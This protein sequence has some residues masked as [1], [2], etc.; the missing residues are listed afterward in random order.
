MINDIRNYFKT[1]I[2]EVDSDLEEHQEYFVNN[3]IDDNNKEETYFITMGPM[4]I[5]RVDSNMTGTM[6]VSIEIWKNG[7]N[8]IIENLDEAYC[9]SIDIQA[10]AMDQS[11]IDQTSYIKSVVG[12]SITPSP[13]ED[14]D[15]LASFVLQFTVTTSFNSY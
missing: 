4:E 12:E 10:K 1:I 2:S 15:N 8:N 9:K 14:N 5:E 11:R 3:N 13:V 7:Y 6:A